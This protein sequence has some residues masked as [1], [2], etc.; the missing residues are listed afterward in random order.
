LQDAITRCARSRL[1]DAEFPAI[2]VSE[3]DAREAE[4]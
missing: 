1:L 3:D 4:E 2:Q